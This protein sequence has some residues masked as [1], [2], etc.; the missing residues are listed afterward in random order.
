MLIS[1]LVIPITA[2]AEM[3][4]STRTS[5]TTSTSDEMQYK[6]TIDSKGNPMVVGANGKA[7]RGEPVDFS[8]QGVRATEILDIKTYTIVEARGS[9]YIL[10]KSGGKSLKFTLPH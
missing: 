5:S 8:Q 6:F 10:V 4:Y 7:I 1:T 3:K 2:C 9:H